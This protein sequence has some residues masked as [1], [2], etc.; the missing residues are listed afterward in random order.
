MVFV[1]YNYGAWKK[2]IKTLLRKRLALKD[3]VRFHKKKIEH[4]EKKIKIL[5][6]NTLPDLEIELDK[7]LERTSK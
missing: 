6:I 1:E 7:Y 3:R 2:E 5:E 4:H